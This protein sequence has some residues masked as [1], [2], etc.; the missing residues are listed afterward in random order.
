M[1]RI[2][3]AN[4]QGGVPLIGAQQIEVPAQVVQIQAQ[5]LAKLLRGELNDAPGMEEAR[6]N[7]LDGL[8]FALSSV[9]VQCDACGQEM[10]RVHH[11]CES[12][13]GQAPDGF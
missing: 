4:G 9:P 6:R 5:L 7:L 10:P 3:L 2:E 13:V 1:K 8:S 11:W 12:C